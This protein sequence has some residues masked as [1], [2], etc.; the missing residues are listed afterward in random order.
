[1]SKRF[2]VNELSLNT[3]KTDIIKINLNHLQDDPFQA[4]YTGKNINNY[5]ISYFGNW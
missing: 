3:D 5:K 4:S 1:M 2:E